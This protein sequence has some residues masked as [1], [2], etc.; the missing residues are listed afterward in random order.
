MSTDTTTK[1]AGPLRCIRCGDED[2]P[3]TKDG[4]CESCEPEAASALRGALEDGGWLDDNA[5]RLMH[6]YAA[7]ILHGAAEALRATPGCES[8]ARIVS[9]LAHGMNR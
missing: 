9:D 7:S 4:L 3:F 5:H 2:G 6:A 8:A 1:P